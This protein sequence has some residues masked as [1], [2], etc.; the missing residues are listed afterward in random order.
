M[1]F[2]GTDGREIFRAPAEKV[3]PGDSYTYRMT[4]NYEFIKADGVIFAISQIYGTED[5]IRIIRINT[6]DGSYQLLTAADQTV[7]EEERPSEGYVTESE[8]DLSVYYIPP[9]HVADGLGEVQCCRMLPIRDAAHSA[10]DSDAIVASLPLMGNCWNEEFDPDALDGLNAQMIRDLADESEDILDFETKL[11]NLTTWACAWGS[12]VV[13]CEYWL[14]AQGRELV[15]TSSLGTYLL[16]FDED[17]GQYHYEMLPVQARNQ[18]TGT[19]TSGTADAVH[20]E[21]TQ[22]TA[23]AA[24]TVI[25]GGL[26]LN[27]LGGHGK[28]RYFNADS[29]MVN[30]GYLWDDEYIYDIAGESRAKAAIG[31]LEFTPLCTQE[32]CKHNSEDCPVH[33]LRGKLLDFG[34]GFR[35]NGDFTLNRINPDGSE[36]ELLTV[37]QDNSGKRFHYVIY[38]TVRP[39]CG[40]SILYISLTGEFLNPDNSV[41]PYQQIDLLYRVSDGSVTVLADQPM[42]LSKLSE[43]CVNWGYCAPAYDDD[44]ALWTTHYTEQTMQLMRIDAQTGARTY[45][46]LPKLDY[47]QW[48]VMGGHFYYRSTDDKWISYDLSTKEEQIICDFPMPSITD[49]DFSD[50]EGMILIQD[51]AGTIYAY[52]RTLSRRETVFRSSTDIATL[53]A[54]HVENGICTGLAN[55][56]A[57]R[58]ALFSFTPFT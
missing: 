57:D 40:G 27:E 38:D 42:P 51:N 13:R 28:L 9:E 15:L 5:T 48:T 49:L 56:G 29:I 50:C 23:A 32:G 46:D 20:T 26:G 17:A 44:T 19:G 30:A 39:L 24:G 3:F 22:T 55:I 18:S 6:E 7:R 25:T 1:T 12:G 58:Y 53:Y 41:N 37:S 2:D 36:T 31:E 11:N 54:V 10:L 33:I 45:Y 21:I 8:G 52:D 4:Q 43:D 35:Q 47:D 14:D 34:S 16:Q